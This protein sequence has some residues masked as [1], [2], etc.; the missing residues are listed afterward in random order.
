MSL[1]WRKRWRR[2]EAIVATS[3]ATTSFLRIVARYGMHAT[4][5]N[6][7]HIVLR[8]IRLNPSS[9]SFFGVED[10]TR[11][12]V[13]GRGCKSTLKTRLPSA[14]RRALL[15]LKSLDYGLDDIRHRITR[16]RL[17]SIMERIYIIVINPLPSAWNVCM[18]RETRQKPKNTNE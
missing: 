9:V 5:W 6:L 4:I 11:T 3:L 2:S 13:D 15:T 17:T 18:R 10:I 14:W 16:M 1:A 8:K 7:S 12:P